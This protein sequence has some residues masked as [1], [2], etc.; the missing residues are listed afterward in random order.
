MLSFIAKHINYC[1]ENNLYSP[2][3]IGET[4]DLKAIKEKEYFSYNFFY[5]KIQ[6]KIENVNIHTKK[7]GNYLVYYHSKGFYTLEKAYKKIIEYIRKNNL[8][9]EG[10]FYEDIILDELAVKG[11][12]NYHI[13]ISIRLFS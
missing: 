9:V 11:Y 3:S 8:E 13:K 5:T 7:M 2:H 10:F 1:K 6:D 4:I 12:E